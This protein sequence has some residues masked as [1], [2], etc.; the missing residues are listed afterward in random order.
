MIGD[1]TLDVL[2]AKNVGARGILV[3]TGH[4]RESEDAACITKDL[5]EAVDWILRQEKQ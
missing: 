5:A 2:L 1:K 3:Q 4:D